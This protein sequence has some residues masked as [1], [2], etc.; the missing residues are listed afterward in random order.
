MPNCCAACTAARVEGVISPL[1]FRS[2]PS[3]S[4]TSNDMCVG[5]VFIVLQCVLFQGP[6]RGR[7][8]M[9]N[10]DATG[11]FARRMFPGVGLLLLYAI[12]LAPARRVCARSVDNLHPLLLQ[13]PL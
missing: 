6:L 10:D 3:I 8:P 13:F 11:Y 12:S 9:C 7:H 2:V 1:G 4:I 5:V